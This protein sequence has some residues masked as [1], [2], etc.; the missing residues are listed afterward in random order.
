[1]VAYSLAQRL[2][3]TLTLA[4]AGVLG[5]LA[6]L[7]A[8][9][10]P[11]AWFESFVLTSGLAA[12]IP[13]AEPPLGATARILLGIAAGGGIALLAW[14]GLTTLGD[15]I[16]RRGASL[17]GPTVR[18]ADAHPD[19]PPREPLR[20]GRDFGFDLDE[21]FEDD[22]AQFDLPEPDLPP[23]PVIARGAPT[24]AVEPERPGPAP[25]KPLQIQ[26]LPADLDQPL[27][28]FDPEALPEAPRAAPPV[29]TPLAPRAPRPSVLAEGERFETFDLA[30]PPPLPL[31]CRPIAGP[32]TE[33]SVHSLLDRLERGINRRQTEAVP[34]PTPEIQPEPV[35]PGLESALESLRKLAVRA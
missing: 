14:F 35:P 19:A 5:V 13:A 28:A 2:N 21:P 12:F 15:Y 20:A 34:L 23:E 10:L 24:P 26:P 9:L 30:P 33:A 18:R 27:A 8:A 31:A 17:R 32:E 6:A 25:T 3:P 11:T 29:V 1:M 7:G 16:T 22:L 4:V